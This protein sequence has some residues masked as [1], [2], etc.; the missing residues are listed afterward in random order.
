LRYYLFISLF[1]WIMKWYKLYFV[2]KKLQP[3]HWNEMI[4][5][6]L[7]RQIIREN[8]ILIFDG[9][10]FCQTLFILRLNSES[11]GIEN[12]SGE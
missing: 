8:S 3:K 11:S 1:Y 5:K 10:L 2:K 7:L 4:N 9:I 12:H 6:L